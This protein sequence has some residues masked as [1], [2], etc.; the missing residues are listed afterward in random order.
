LLEYA[1]VVTLIAIVALLA[2][3]FFGLELDET[4]SAIGASTASLTG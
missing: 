1:F 2:V 3:R 4:F